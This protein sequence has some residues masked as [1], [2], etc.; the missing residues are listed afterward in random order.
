M[1]KY[2][3]TLSDDHTHHTVTDSVQAKTIKS[4]LSDAVRLALCHAPE[5]Q[6][7]PHQEDI[8]SLFGTVPL[9]V[10]EIIR[11]SNKPSSEVLMTLAEYELMGDIERLSG[12][13]FLK[14][15]KK[16]A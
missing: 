15:P 1:I 7:P 16:L 2:L 11:L 8:L 5:A 14:I 12:N 10:D 4:D 9:S 6:Q 3:K 13:M